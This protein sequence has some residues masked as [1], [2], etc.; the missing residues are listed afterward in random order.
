MG[1]KIKTKVKRDVEIQK[2][3]IKT[4][5]SRGSLCCCLGGSRG[6]G[7]VFLFWSKMV[8]SIYLTFQKGGMYEN[9]LFS[10]V[11]RSRKCCNR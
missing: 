8:S 9:T 11:S 4:S 2:I 6:L 10:K 3:F 5:F 1:E 7:R